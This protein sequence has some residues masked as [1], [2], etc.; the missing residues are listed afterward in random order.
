MRSCIRG[1]ARAALACV[2]RQDGVGRCPA[3]GTLGEGWP[4]GEEV[5]RNVGWVATANAAGGG[6][7]RLGEHALRAQ[8]RG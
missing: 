2:D 6:H 1:D 8:V 5:E 3:R 7:G 4:R